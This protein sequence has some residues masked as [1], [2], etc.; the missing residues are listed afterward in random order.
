MP[1]L[2]RC[3]QDESAARPPFACP[4]LKD[5][6]RVMGQTAAILLYLG[7]RLKL[8]G[9]SEADHIWTHQISAFASNDNSDVT[10]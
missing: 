10:K 2:L 5:G 7:P 6:K 1:A 3:L 9:A 8:V 4:V